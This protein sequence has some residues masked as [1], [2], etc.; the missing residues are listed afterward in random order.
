MI[1]VASIPRCGSTYLVRSIAGLGPGGST[2]ENIT[3]HGVVKTHRPPNEVGGLEACDRAIF[4]FGD[5]VK[6]VV[7]TQNHRHDPTHFRNLG[8]EYDPDV[9]L[10]SED[11]LGYGD[12]PS[13]WE[14]AP[15][16]VLWIRYRALRDDHPR[17]S[18]E[19]WI[20][21]PVDWI[22]W[23]PRRTDPTKEQRRKVRA[24]YTDLVS[25]VESSPEEWVTRP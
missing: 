19:R 4:L 8:R 14:K 5:A 1:C 6:A 13:A 12:L 2:P 20:E 16:P 23:Q 18:V 11:Y 9:D 15:L 24:A 10:L 22:E 21:R 3:S 7:S 17:W 25:W